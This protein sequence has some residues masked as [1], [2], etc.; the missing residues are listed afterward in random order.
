MPAFAHKFDTNH[1]LMLSNP[2][3]LPW[4]IKKGRHHTVIS[5]VL[6]LP[7]LRTT[8]GRQT[9][10]CSPSRLQPHL[11]QSLSSEDMS[12]D[13]LALLRNE[14]WGRVCSKAE[15]E[16]LFLPANALRGALHTP[17]LAAP[18]ALRDARPGI[19]FAEQLA[20][21]NAQLPA[22]AAHES[23]LV[24]ASAACVAAQCCAAALQDTLP[25][26][27][28]GQRDRAA[29]ASAAAFVIGAGRAVLDGHLPAA[30]ADG[31][32]TGGTRRT[33][34]GGTAAAT[35]LVSAATEQ[36]L[37]FC[38]LLGLVSEERRGHLFAEDGPLPPQAVVA[39]LGTV[40]R[41]QALAAQQDRT[42]ER[43]PM[44]L[45]CTFLRLT[46]L[47]Y[48]TMPGRE[49]SDSA[50]PARG[51]ALLADA[52]AQRSIADM[53]LDVC[54]PQA[55]AGLRRW[56]QRQ[57]GDES[58]RSGGGG[59][60]APGGS[61]GEPGITF[62]ALEVL[63]MTL[64]M[65]VLHPAIRARM[66]EANALQI[67]E[68]AANVVAALPISPPAELSAH[69]RKMLRHA[70]AAAGQLLG[71]LCSQL[72]HA[73]ESAGT[74]NSDAAARLQRDSLAAAWHVVELFPHAANTLEGLLADDAPATGMKE[75][76]CGGYCDALRQLRAMNGMHN[77]RQVAAWAAAVQAAVALVPRLS[78]C[79]SAWQASGDGGDGTGWNLAA[80]LIERLCEHIIQD[81]TIDAHSWSLTAQQAAA[82]A[83]AELAAHAVPRADGPVWSLWRAHSAT[84][85]L[86]HWLAQ[87]GAAEM[88]AE[89]WHVQGGFKALCQ[90]LS[91]QLGALHRLLAQEQHAFAPPPECSRGFFGAACAAHLEACHAIDA[92]VRSGR[93]LMGSA[94]LAAP[95]GLRCIFNSNFLLSLCITMRTCPQLADAACIQL[96]RR[97]F[98]SAS[99]PKD[100]GHNHTTAATMLSNTAAH[101]AR[102]PLPR[103]AAVLAA[104]GLLQELLEEAVVL[105]G[106]GLSEQAANSAGS[107]QAALGTAMQESA[108]IHQE[109]LAAA[110]S[111][112]GDDVQQQLRGRLHEESMQVLR[113]QVQV[114]PIPIAAASFQDYAAK[115]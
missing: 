40:A 52:S 33:A 11:K 60:A 105:H 104:A 107:C 8:H 15:A 75:L 9:A 14:T 63:G 114:G 22:A 73:S 81:S 79:S 27:R 16:A 42:L 23:A 39:W 78:A 26:G 111:G 44:R 1:E 108:R 7:P 96:L 37:A 72:Q 109:L 85:R 67:V 31:R 76:A 57:A 98:A 45:T 18:L 61:S 38:E 50:L 4:H 13:L 92:L 17:Q 6:P 5:P 35:R 100:G 115:L 32:S 41:A 3:M 113:A 54:L 74:T 94:S 103:L 95:G 36:A 49:T 53:L 97:L 51:R 102:A 82:E 25:S 106:A 99:A 90:G 19:R 30:L 48:A 24:Q 59:D 21:L 69:E 93:L 2:P 12:R 87:E 83:A 112:G 77:V 110:G 88:A 84:C 65:T 101:A 71:I 62:S 91:L 86:V 58:D 89:A 29:L 64:A 28:A 20:A 46:T 56:Q 80:L 43:T 10:C 70:Q 47:L 66:H 55:L 68:A 34:A